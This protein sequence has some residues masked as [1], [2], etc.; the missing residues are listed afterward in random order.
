MEGTETVVVGYIMECVENL[1]FI[2]DKA[3]IID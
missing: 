2:D 3:I 1:V